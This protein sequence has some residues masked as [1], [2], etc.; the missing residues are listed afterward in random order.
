MACI[1]LVYSINLYYGWFITLHSAGVGL[2]VKTIFNINTGYTYNTN[3]IIENF[4]QK[5]HYKTI[6]GDP[7]K[8]LI[9]DIAIGSVSNPNPTINISGWQSSCT[10]ENSVMIDIAPNGLVPIYDLIPD[11]SKA[12]AVKNYIINI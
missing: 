11:Q 6:G 7:T 1:S 9:G 10:P 4:S 5:L 12:L 8:S 3:D 2:H